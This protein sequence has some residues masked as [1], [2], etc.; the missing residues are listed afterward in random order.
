MSSRGRRRPSLGAPSRVR[1]NFT[2]ATL[3]VKGW[4]QRVHGELP[5]PAMLHSGCEAPGMAE[6][7]P[8]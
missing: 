7:K 6:M 1:A 3:Q 5:A 4:L 8:N 2:C